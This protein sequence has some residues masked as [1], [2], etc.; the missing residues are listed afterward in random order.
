MTV[1][2]GFTLHKLLNSF[3]AAHVDL[4]RGRDLFRRTIDAIRT[5]SVM[6]ND[7]PARLAEVLAQLWQFGG[8]GGG[9]GGGGTGGSLMLKVRCRM[10]MSLVYDSVWRWREE[11]EAQGRASLDGE[12]RMKS[13]TLLWGVP[14]E[15]L[16]R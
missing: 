10:S 11:F 9:G 8:A 5:I 7:L 16:I 3:F 2:A 12:F 1:A 13:S 15:V 6:N 4:E 14:K